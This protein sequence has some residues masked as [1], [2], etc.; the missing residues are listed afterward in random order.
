MACVVLIL[1][2]RINLPAIYP[3]VGMMAMGGFAAYGDRL[4]R[5]RRGNGNGSGSGNG[6]SE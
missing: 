1:I 3:V 5:K 6:S 2:D 4:L